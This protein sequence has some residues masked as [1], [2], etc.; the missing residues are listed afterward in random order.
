MK[1]STSGFIG[2]AL[3]STLA[4]SFASVPSVAFAV[5]HR[6]TQV[7][8]KT[9]YADGVTG[10]TAATYDSLFTS[11]NA[12]QG[13]AALIAAG[14]VKVNDVPVPTVTGDGEYSA[15]Q[16]DINGGSGLWEN[17]DGSWSYNVQI[18]LQGSNE[19]YAAAVVDFV[20]AVTLMRGI[21][22]RL[23]VTDGV[24]TAMSATIKDVAFANTVSKGSKSTEF[25]IAGHGD[26]GTDKPNPSTISFPNN[27]VAGRPKSQNMVLYWEDAE[28]WHLERAASKN[29][30]LDVS[31]DSSGNLTESVDGADFTDSRLTLQYSEPWNRPTQPFRAMYWMGENNVS[32]TQ[33]F[34]TPGVTVGF[35]RGAG[36]R[37][38]LAAALTKANK[39]LSTVAVS[40]AGDG[41]DVA[42][43]TMWVT[44]AYHDIFDKAVADAQAELD[45]EHATNSE[46]E[47]AL[48]R[49]AQAYGGQTGDRFSWLE[50]T[51]FGSGDDYGFGEPFDTGYNGTGF[52]TFAQAHL[53]TGTGS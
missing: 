1:K 11:G 15:D 16:L 25:T 3:A 4:M 34:A 21:S 20:N 30:V 40:S 32:A 6:A 10:I 23:T 42:E 13:V 17:A 48:Y 44:Q 28:G 35:S 24:V 41:S 18:L 7:T 26:G 50:N 49:L 27:N 9:I 14:A 53:G 2:V 47:G 46:Y 8:T 52:W 31:R 33:W 39:A 12:E 29:V 43:G 36:A 45:S 37:P 51:Y 22:Y 19:S 38:A 5:P